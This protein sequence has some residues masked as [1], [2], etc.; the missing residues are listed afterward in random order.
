[1]DV[2]PPSPTLL[3]RDGERAC[4]VASSSEGFADDGGVGNALC[5]ALQPASELS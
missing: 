1:M 4:G 3:R 5:A 2:R